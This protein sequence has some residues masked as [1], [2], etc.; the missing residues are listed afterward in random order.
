MEIDS[1]TSAIASIVAQRAALI[2]LQM[3]PGRT[4]RAR[5]AADGLARLLG[6]TTD[7]VA[8]LVK[9]NRTLKA[10]N[11]RLE[12]ELDRISKGWEDLR[13]LARAAPRGRRR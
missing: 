8:R 7:V 5:P 11:K 10:Q 6:E 9:E 2:W 13:K 3:P 1:R 12:A 4:R